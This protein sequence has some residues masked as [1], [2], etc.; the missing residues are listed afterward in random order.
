MEI[1]KYKYTMD[2]KCRGDV[3]LL[4]RAGALM[5]ESLDEY[6]NLAELTERTYLYANSMQTPQRKIPFPNGETF[7][8]WTACLLEYEKEYE[9]FKKHTEELKQGILPT[10][11]TSE[12][13][14]KPLV[15]APFT[16]LGDKSCEIYDLKKGDSVFSDCSCKMINLAPELEK[17]TGVRMGLGAAI[18]EGVT[19]TLE[20]PQD[21][22]ILIGYMDAK[23]VEWL[24]LPDLETNTHADD[25]GGLTVVY[26]SAIKAEACPPINIHAYKYEKGTHE[27]FFGTGAFMIAGV[28]AA[29][30]VFKSRN[31]NLGGEGL[32]TLDWLY[33]E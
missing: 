29:D 10:D 2:E 27:I 3:A 28:V 30:T 5:K 1:L 26:G 6:M 7:G 15:P 31:A 23:G 25:R 14:V 16:L 24:Q 11:Q 19:V 21:S 32:D 13:N 22:Y 12:V 17:L 9:N 33:E 8:H 4:E 18:E 20:L